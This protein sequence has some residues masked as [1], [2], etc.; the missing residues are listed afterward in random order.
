MERIKALFFEETLRRW[1]FEN[2]LEASGMSRERVNHYLKELLKER[3]IR[4]VKPRG[5][6]PYYIAN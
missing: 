1:H 5:R 6:M 3:L 2:I 4:R